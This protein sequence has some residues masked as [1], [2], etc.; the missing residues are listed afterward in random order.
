[1]GGDLYPPS[2]EPLA[3]ILPVQSYRACPQ[4]YLFSSLW[5]LQEG[6]KATLTFGRV[7]HG[8]FAMMLSSRRATLF[9]STK[10]SAFTKPNGP[11]GLRRRLSGGRYKKDGWSNCAR[12]H[13]AVLEQPSLVLELEKTFRATGRKQRHS[14]SRI[15]QVNSLGRSEWKLSITRRASQEKTRT[16]RKT[17]N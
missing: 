7:M 10:C 16:H 11:G 3:L 13:Q 15:D 17:S 12:F 1:M 2:P 14:E 5:S 8:T 6:P 4:R 9:L